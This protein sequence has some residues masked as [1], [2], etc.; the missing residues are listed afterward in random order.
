MQHYWERANV[1]QIDCISAVERTY[2]PCGAQDKPIRQDG[3]SLVRMD[4]TEL[5]LN[6]TA[7]PNNVG[8]C[9][10]VLQ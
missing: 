1:E 6:P 7:G 5:T 3:A 4:E 10:V 9:L 8:N 2:L